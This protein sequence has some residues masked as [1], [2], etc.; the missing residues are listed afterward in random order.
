MFTSKFFKSLLFIVLLSI[1]ALHAQTSLKPKIEQYKLSN[2]LTVILQEDSRLPKVQGFVVTRAGSINDPADATGL[3]HYLEHLLF[4]GT[5][6]MGTIDWAKEKPH[7]DQIVALYD[8]LGNTKDKKQREAIQLQINEESL[9]AAQYSIPNELTKLID[10]IGG[11][12]VNAFTSY[13]ITA[14]H[15]MF[16]SSQVERWLTLYSHIFEQPVFR[17]FQAELETVYEEYNMYSD[18]AMS[19]LQTEIMKN[20]FKKTPYGRPILGYGEHLKNPSLTRL[21]EFYS[22]YYVPGNMALILCGDIDAAAV[23]PMIEATFGKWASKPVPQQTA[24][25][26]DPFKG[27]ELLKLKLGPYDQIQ[28]AF[29]GVVSGDKDE[30]VL[31]ICSN[32]LSNG[33]S[34]LLDELVMETKMLSAGSGNS[35]LKNSGV[36]QLYMIPNA[37]AYY[38]G[39]EMSTIRTPDQYR[40]A[41]RQLDVAR[42]KAVADGDKL[43]VAQAKRLADGDFSDAL[44]ISVKRSM[45]NRFVRQQESISSRARTLAQMFAYNTDLDEYVNYIDKVNAITKDDVVRVAKKYFTNNYMVFQIAP[46]SSKKD[47]IEKPGYKA[48]EFPNAEK[49]SAFAQVLYNIKTPEQ[50]IPYIDFNTDIRTTTLRNGTTVYHSQN[51]LNDIF[52]LTLRYGAGTKK[53]KDLAQVSLL[54]TGSSG[55]WSARDFKAK[56]AEINSSLYVSA[57]DSYTHVTITGPGENFTR[58][59]ALVNGFLNNTALYQNQVSRYAESTNY[60]RKYEREEPSVMSAALFDYVRYGQQ[61]DYLDRPSVEE[62]R[63]LKAE[64]IVAAFKLATQHEATFFYTGTLSPTQLAMQLEQGLKMPATPLKSDGLLVREANQVKEN[65]VYLVNYP[66]LQAQIRLFAN[67]KV[68]DISDQVPMVAFNNYF[69]SGFTG[70]VLQELRENR[71]LAY[72]AGANY[73]RPPILGKPCSFTGS[74]QTQSDKTLIATEA[75]MDLI[76]NMPKKPERLD[77]LKQYLKLSSVNRPDFREQAVYIESSR[78]LGYTEDPL[79]TLLPKYAALTFGD[80]ETFWSQNIKDVPMAIMIVGDK[81]QMDMKAL[82][83]F[84]KIVELRLNDIFSKDE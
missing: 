73:S 30:L 62:L 23:K 56:L 53:I 78:R 7:Y 21:Q 47:N 74:I 29:R 26:E 39:P 35:S 18:Q 24:Q 50:T 15:S 57:D 34:G 65:I 33:Q 60:S 19:Q 63:K 8:Q 84:G 67:G 4:K 12:G 75:F 9:K 43:L 44:L 40:Y 10:N 49:S 81:K 32:L 77:N 1:T 46:G 11:V 48:L 79:K 3:A 42:M 13:D 59:L 69:S 5:T 38:D 72:G 6:D 52:S 27:R 20:L 36:F 61:S 54:N 28:I 41:I 2:G 58:I 64:E 31:D 17:A 22:T 16:P 45:I 68:F 55:G 71:S 82:A 80:I 14:Y 83:K 25:A 66:A 51:P 76:R 70:L 37:Q